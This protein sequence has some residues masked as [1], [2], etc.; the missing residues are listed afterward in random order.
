MYSLQ[1]KRFMYSHQIELVNKIGHID[2][3]LL[4]C[5]YEIFGYAA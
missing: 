2:I 1:I 4:K 5:I 3:I